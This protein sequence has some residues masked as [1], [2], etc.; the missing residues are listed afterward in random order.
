MTLSYDPFSGEN[1]NVD[2]ARIEGVEAAYEYAAG[3]WSARVEA[4]VQDPK[5]LTTDEQLYRRAKESLTVA[6][7]RT[8]GSVDLGVDVLATGSRALHDAVLAVLDR[9]MDAL[10]AWLDGPAG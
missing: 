6:V 10:G 7:A 3:P 5:N 2:E 9:G 1:R 4:I 8:F